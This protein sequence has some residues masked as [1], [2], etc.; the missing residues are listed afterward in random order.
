MEHHALHHEG[1]AS[2]YFVRPA[3]IS[4]SGQKWET[5]RVA[6][7][8]VNLDHLKDNILRADRDKIKQTYK[9]LPDLYY[10]DEVGAV[11]TP[12]RFDRLDSKVVQQSSKSQ[13]AKL[14]ELYSGSTSLAA[15]ARHKRI[16]H[17]PPIDLRYGWY[18]RRRRDQTLI[19]YMASLS[20]ECCAYTQR[21]TVR[22]G[23]TLQPT[24]AGKC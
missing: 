14:W 6:I 2:T 20:L 5:A 15:R 7:A 18:T 24:Y 3:G 1:R 22:C 4:S 23:E 11:V 19:L 10:Q 13:H 21:Q 16:P 17:L 12:D 8:H 9:N